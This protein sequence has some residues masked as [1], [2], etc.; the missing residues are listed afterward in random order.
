M[1]LDSL[2]SKLHHSIH[3]KNIHNFN[4]YYDQLLEH[5]T[6]K[7]HAHSVLMDCPEDYNSYCWI[8]EILDR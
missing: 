5:T 7:D 8:S 6:D 3:S 4:E 2:L 1:S